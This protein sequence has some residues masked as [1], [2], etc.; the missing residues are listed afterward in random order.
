MNGSK[1]VAA[2][3]ILVILV[4]TAGCSDLLGDGPLEF[5][6]S[7]STVSE[8]PL[9]STGF[10]EV[11]VSTYDFNRTITVGNETRTINVTNHVAAYRKNGSTVPENGSAVESAFGVL[12]TPKAEVLGEPTNPLGSL[13][14]KTLMQRAISEA[15]SIND[16]Q[17]EGTSTVTMLGTETN[18]TTYS[19][20]VSRSGQTVEVTAYVARV[21]HGDDYVI[22][23]GFHRAGAS[24]EAD[25]IRSLIRGI[26]H[27]SG[28]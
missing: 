10:E 1:R 14:K 8:Q 28:D 17:I 3:G 18:L 25:A 22:A 4:A 13:D 24:G 19:G 7:Q 5:T 9:S 21:G 6:A 12:T 2:V 26:T 23:S 15:K 20:T 16:L 27:E 11:E